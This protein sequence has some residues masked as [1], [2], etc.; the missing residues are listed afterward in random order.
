M[1]STSSSSTTTITVDDLRAWLRRS[2][3]LIE[4]EA[5]HLT[6]LDAAIGDADHGANMARGFRAVL[7]VLDDESLRTVDALLKKVGMTLVSR[8]GGASGPLY[9][10]FFLRLGTAAPGAEELDAAAF[11][12]AVAAGIEG[13]AQRG[14]AE[15]G[16]KTML[17]A[18]YPALAALR[19]G[20]V[21]AAARA[22]EEGRDAAIGLQATKGRASY[23]GERSIGHVDP[24]SESTVLLWRAAAETLGGAA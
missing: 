22:A 11:A 18:W 17:D 15:Q 6:E 16:E 9:G 10:T 12:D 14:R 5:A 1:D 4:Q 19:E 13:I 21:A 2:A 8:V 7:E 24:G 3:E 20:G 23:L